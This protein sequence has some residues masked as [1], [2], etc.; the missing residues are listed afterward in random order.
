MNRTRVDDRVWP[1]A[2]MYFSDINNICTT[3]ILGWKTPISVR[4]GYTPDISAYLL[5]QFWEPIYFKIDEK[6]PST[7]ELEG[8]WLRVSKTVGDILTYDILSLMSMKVIQRSTIRSADPKKTSIINKRIIT[9]PDNDEELLVEEDEEAQEDP[10]HPVSKPIKPRERTNK[11]KVKWHDTEEAS[12]DQT[13]GTTGFHDT[14]QGNERDFR[15]RKTLDDLPQ[16]HP[17]RRKKVSRDSTRKHLLSTATLMT[18]LKSAGN[19]VI[20]SGENVMGL[21][22]DVH[23]LASVFDPSDPQHILETD[24]C[25][26][27]EEEWTPAVIS[28]IKAT[29]D[30]DLFEG[31]KD[32]SFEP[33]SVLD[34][35]VTKVLVRKMEPNPKPTIKLIKSR[36]V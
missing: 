20:D 22:Q 9:S 13:E 25:C 10:S 30:H 27:D 11:H 4:H 18:L 16:S 12:Y 29:I 36:Q 14:T 23:P 34:H 31:A 24:L 5:Y 19:P 3:P 32:L 17:L 1:W 15:P 8:R 6:S 2:Y 7:K 35:R 28:N 33:S 26:Q 21:S